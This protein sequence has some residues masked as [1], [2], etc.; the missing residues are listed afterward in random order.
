MA[1]APGEPDS[2]I[3]ARGVPPAGDAAMIQTSLRTLLTSL[4]K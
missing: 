3:V 2:A 1:D 4:Q